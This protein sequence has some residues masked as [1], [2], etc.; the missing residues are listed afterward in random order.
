VTG[1]NVAGGLV[2]DNGNLV[3]LSYATGTVTGDERVG[4]LVGRNVVYDDN[5]AGDVDR[6]YATGTVTGDERVS[7]LVGFNDNAVRRSYATG[8]VAGSRSVGGLVGRS[9][10]P[11]NFDPAVVT[12]S[13][14]TGAVAGTAA[15]GLIGT[16]TAVVT[17]GYWDATATGQP[18]SAGGTPLATGEVTGPA[19]RTTLSGFGFPGTWVAT[20]GYPR[21][22]WTPTSLPLPANATV[23]VGG[24]TR[25][26]V[27]ARFVDETTDT[28]TTTV[29]Y[30]A[31]DRRVAT[32]TDDG[33][34]RGVARGTTAV[35]ARIGTAS[36]TT[37]TVTAACPPIDGRRGIDADGDG[38]CEDVNGDGTV[39]IDDPIA[40]LL[41][42][43]AALTPEGRTALDFDRDGDVDVVD[44]IDLLFRL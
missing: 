38:R 18:T 14:A 3:R 24:T 4:G 35:T 8:A 32:G 1:R 15:G 42:D 29:T 9:E 37:V 28:A 31:D 30:T 36:A 11:S 23:V 43:G 39:D 27:T 25:P 10:D 12:E 16:G 19:A 13:Y 5:S 20:D 17:D 21:L 7:G 41:V 6:S 22:A 44:A 34:I 2:A 40:L 33:R 26:A